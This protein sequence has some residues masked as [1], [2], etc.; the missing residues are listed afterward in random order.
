MIRDYMKTSDV[1][2]VEQRDA[3]R[4]TMGAM[5]QESRVV[6]KENRGLRP[7]NDMNWK[8]TALFTNCCERGT[9][10]ENY[11]LLFF[12]LF[13][14]FLEVAAPAPL[15]DSPSS[16]TASLGLSSSPL[17]LPTR[18]LPD[19]MLPLS[20]PIELDPRPVSLF[21][22]LSMG[23]G[24]SDRTISAGLAASAACMLD[25]RPPRERRRAIL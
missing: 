5:K 22:R 1:T 13:L 15:G 12:L 9:T 20:S 21:I 17:T 24:D 18:I 3:N 16:A 23:L 25:R 4:E 14:I 19:L 6:S 11:F 8:S 10:P 7:G 2:C